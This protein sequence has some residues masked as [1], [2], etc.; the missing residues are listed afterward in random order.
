MRPWSEEAHVVRERQSLW[1]G[2]PDD[3]ELD[4]REEFRNLK[5]GVP[6]EPT[7]G[8]MAEVA[9]DGALSR[10]MFVIRLEEPR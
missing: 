1:L 2:V 5:Q 9:D 4:V 3:L 7:R 8:E 6:I 10:R